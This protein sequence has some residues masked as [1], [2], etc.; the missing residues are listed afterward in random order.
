MKSQLG[1]NDFVL[2]LSIRSLRRALMS[3]PKVYL[4]SALILLVLINAPHASSAL[5]QSRS[6]NDIYRGGT[7]R[8]VS[9]LV[10]DDSSTPDDVFFEG[11]EHPS[12]IA[13][14][15]KGNMYIADYAANHIKCFDASGKFL[16]L[17][18]REGQGPGELSRPYTLT[19]SKD[20]LVIWDMGN[21]RFSIIATDGTPVKQRS[22]NR[23]EEGWPWKIRSLSTGDIL[24]ETQK[25]NYRV[26]DAPQFTELRLYSPLMEFKKVVFSQQVFTQKIIHNPTRNIPQPFVGRVYWDVTP[27]GQIVIGFSGSPE[28][29]IYDPE[30][31]KIA[32]FTFKF[33]AIKVT[34][35]DKKA[36]FDGITYSQ[37]GQVTQGAPDYMKNNVD[38][39]KNKPAFNQIVVDSEGNI[40]V[41]L[42]G[43]DPSQDYKSFQA[44]DMQGRVLGEVKIL[45]GSF[46]RL[47][48]QVL[49]AAFWVGSSDMDDLIKITRYRIQN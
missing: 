17:L 8:F 35:K 41:S 2:L 25:Q 48:A 15:E 45:E 21:S 40:L 19:F 29:G 24:L 46:P 49:D 5:G 22:L 13:F 7:V 9:D 26:P 30:K 34:D 47:G 33:P 27:N 37:G 14:D 16:K 31:G 28:I 18:G 36:F 6:L 11:F 39:P 38:F 4:T 43:K 3:Q 20:N 44:F 32:S 12:A 42:Y 10:L 23:N 1:I